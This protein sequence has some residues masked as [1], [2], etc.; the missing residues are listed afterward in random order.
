MNFTDGR[1]IASC[2]AL[3]LLFLLFEN[4]FD[5]Q[6]LLKNLWEWLKLL[7]KVLINPKM[8]LTF[9]IAWMITNGWSYVF[10]GFGI[11]FD[12]KWMLSIGLGYQAFLWFP[13]TAEKIITVA[14]AIFLA[15]VL[16]P[17]D[18]KLQTELQKLSPKKHY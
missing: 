14:I 16:F 9:G 11:R 1:I 6:K 15:K 10:V 2:F 5:K 4:T 12:I 18:I 3:V 17:R 13:F 7:G 8:L